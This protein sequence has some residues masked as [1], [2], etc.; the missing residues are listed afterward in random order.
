M[1]LPHTLA[2]A[3]ADLLEGM[4][5][6]ALA[7]AAGQISQ[8]YR[9][10]RTSQTIVSPL[11][12]TAYAVTRMPATYAACAAVFARIK[13]VTPDFAPSSLVD[14]GAGTGA[15]SWAA[16]TAWTSITSS[17]LLDH[18]PALR[19]LAAQL[20][21]ANADIRAGSISQQVPKADLVVASYVLVELTQDRAGPV[22]L[23]LWQS[24]NDTL[25]LIEPGTP[26]GFERIRAARTA[27]I[28]SGAHMLAPC[29]HDADCPLTT[30]DWCHFS[31]RL[32]RSRD[33]MLLKEAQVP[34]EDERYCYIVATRQKI[35]RGARILSPPLKTKSGLTF[36]L[37]EESGLRVELV[38]ARDKQHHRSVRKLGWGDL[39]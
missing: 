14:M 6:Q 31:Q 23:D 17:I 24:A 35:S 18:N 32:G 20:G 29:T 26:A 27:L 16:A 10:G 30:N 22:A 19:E 36:K 25:A 28:S 3:L 33:H 1:Q 39:F 5:R 13:E 8:D 4:P 15:A 7:R 37:C 2:T 9:Q 12:A 11:Q 34:F 38:Q 21:L